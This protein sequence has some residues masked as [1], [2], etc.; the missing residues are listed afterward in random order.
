MSPNERA[1]RR[2]LGHLTHFGLISDEANAVWMRNADPSPPAA[3]GERLSSRTWTN[4]Y[5]KVTCEAC[6]T[7]I[8]S[9]PMLAD[10]VIALLE[11]KP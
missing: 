7:K 8:E 5:D 3:C 10:E 2:A 1:A 4:K 9:N 6:I 11:S